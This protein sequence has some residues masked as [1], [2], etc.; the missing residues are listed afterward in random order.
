VLLIAC[1]NV[2]SLSLARTSTRGRELAVRIALGARP[3]RIVQQLLTESLVLS[4]IGGGLGVLLALWGVDG[5]RLIGPRD[6][7]RLDEVGVDGLV[8]AV[9]VALS[10]GSGLAFGL[11]PAW[12]ASRGRFGEVVHGAR[13]VTQSRGSSR[14]HGALVVV[15]VALSLVLLISASLC[16][17]SFQRLTTVPLGLEPAHLLTFMLP[18]TP[19]HKAP[20]DEAVFFQQ[21]LDRIAAQPGI[22]AAGGANA[23]APV[24]LQRGTGF[25]IGDEAPTGGGD[26]FAAF[27]GCTPDYFRAL[28]TAVVRGRAF[29]SDDRADAPPVA[30]LN[31]T[32]AQRL[33]PKGDAVGQRIRLVN[34]QAAAT[35]REIVGIV[36]DVKYQ[37]LDMDS[38]DTIYTPYAQTPFEWIYVDVRTQGE[39][40]AMAGTIKRAIAELDPSQPVWRITPM[41]AVVYESVSQPRFELTLVALFAM[42]ALVLALVGLYGVIAYL[43]AQR[44]QE[45]GIRIALGAQRGDV[46]RLVVGRGL[47]LTVAGSLIGVVVAAATTRLLRAMLFHVS[48]TDPLV[49]VAVPLVFAA[50]SLVASWLPARRAASV[51]PMIALRDE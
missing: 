10:I 41:S 33:F 43:V 6:V 26:R 51:D 37:G 38:P 15:E 36:D 42:L 16:M 40:L 31:R 30:I 20:A 13:G 27:V 28:G 12:Q 23:Q 18:P 5:L 48:P 4:L 7:P 3:R 32:L 17:R 11:L 29:G 47:A 50:V 35:P 24:S 8:L 34:P 9:A 14:L 21:L 22:A 1:A 46:L 45:I 25:A 49:F 19:R 2:A 39:P 44:T